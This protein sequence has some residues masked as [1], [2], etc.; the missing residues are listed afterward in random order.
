[1]NDDV[2]AVISYAIITLFLIVAIV[3]PKVFYSF[4]N[5]YMTAT[6]KDKIVKN[7]NKS[8]KYLIFTDKEV[9]QNTDSLFRG[10]F[11]SSDVYVDLEVGKTYEF[12]LIGWRIKFFSVYK[13]I[14]EYKEIQIN[15]K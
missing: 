15:E 10:K 11:N 8:S 7:G 5:S 2:I 3:I 6:I 1:M 14:I 9:L 13:N 4:N 12:H